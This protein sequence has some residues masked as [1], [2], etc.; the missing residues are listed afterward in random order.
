MSIQRL[1]AIVALCLFAAMPAHARRGFALINTGDELFEVAEFPAEI[2]K[3][4]PAAASAKVGYKCSHFG[5]FWADIWTWDCKLVAVTGDNS[6]GDLPDDLVAKLAT[7]SQYAMSH[8]RRGF[9]NHYAFW[10]L[11]GAFAAFMVF[12]MFTGKRPAA[13]AD[14]VPA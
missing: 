8:A 12:A 2:V 1:L 9:W 6:Y 11:I 4:I 14:S 7:D 10:S 5:L 3:A 13:G